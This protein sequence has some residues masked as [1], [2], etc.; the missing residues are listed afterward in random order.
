MLRSILLLFAV[1]AAYGQIQSALTR[2]GEWY[3]QTTVG[4]IDLRSDARLGVKATGPIT[5]RG[6]DQ[7]GVSFTVRQK[8]KARN[9]ADARRILRNIIFRNTAR[10]GW[11]WISVIGADAAGVTSELHLNVPR[12][13][14]QL[15][16][17]SQSGDVQ[18]YDLDGTVEAETAGGRVQMDRIGGSVTAKTGGSEIR[19]GRVG[20][21][22]RCFS[23][24][25]TIRVDSAGGE[26]W[27][28]TAGGEI[29]VDD[30]GGALH[31]TTA[32]GNIRVN[33]A[34]GFIVARSD[35]GL[36]DVQRAG[37]VVTAQT[38]GGSIQVGAAEGVRCESA[39]GAI[40]VRSSSG[41]LRAETAAGSILAELLPGARLEE[42]SLSTGSGD[43]TVFIPSN[44]AV[45]VQAINET[46]GRSNRIVSDF[47]QIR[48]RRPDASRQT[49]SIAEGS[50]NGGGPLLR[51]SVAAGTIYLRRK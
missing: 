43:I 49:P 48:V 18:A 39:A 29:V 2:E 20:G 25:G 11:N 13:V 37:G 50:L 34:T 14:S 6:R 16:M 47:P 7:S 12:S 24:G 9:E 44:I 46:P 35:G 40:R 33:K 42:S 10:S 41:P 32:G 5:V 36:I 23:G 22:L 51:I 21:G 19:I 27:C 30:I 8:T 4:G 1:G 3:I 28:E 26:T 31:A 17:S 38:R 45:S 15:V